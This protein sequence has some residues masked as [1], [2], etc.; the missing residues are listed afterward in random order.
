MTLQFIVSASRQKAVL[1]SI[2]II[3]VI[4]I[5]I[6]TAYA[7]ASQTH[8]GTVGGVDWDAFDSIDYTYGDNGIVYFGV[9]KT[10]ADESMTLSHS[11]AG[12]EMCG[13]LIIDT[14]WST[15]YTSTNSVQ[16]SSYPPS[17]WVQPGICSGMWFAPKIVI[18]NLARHQVVNDTDSDEVMLEAYETLPW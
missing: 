14:D 17:G 5:S 2:A 7:Y 3:A 10:R 13:V 16:I 11:T 9:T 15:S 12:R 18:S 1:A 4:L 6:T 8:E